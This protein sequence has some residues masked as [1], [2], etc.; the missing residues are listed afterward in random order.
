MQEGSKQRVVFIMENVQMISVLK[1]ADKK[2][3]HEINSLILIG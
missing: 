3:C 1:T 2:V